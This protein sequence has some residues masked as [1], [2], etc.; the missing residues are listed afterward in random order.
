VRF[1][2]IKP[3]DPLWIA[4]WRHHNFMRADHVVARFDPAAP[5]AGITDMSFGTVTDEINLTVPLAVSP[6]RHTNR[7]KITP[8]G[9][10]GN[11]IKGV[12]I[13]RSGAFNDT[14]FV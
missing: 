6:T 11:T 7:V 5:F 14:L 4:F 12:V 8:A 1:G 13:P 10:E 2:R 9:L 3:L